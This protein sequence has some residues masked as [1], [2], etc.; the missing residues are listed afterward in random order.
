MNY[1]EQRIGSREGDSAN[2]V[3]QV[4]AGHQFPQPSLAVAM[5]LQ[6]V[7]SDALWFEL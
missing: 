1:E 2:F 7:R 3:D 5:P 6:V 4:W